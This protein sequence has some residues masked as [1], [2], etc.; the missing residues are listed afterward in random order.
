MNN[1]DE[2]SNGTELKAPYSP[3]DAFKK[4]MDK[5]SMR[6]GKAPISIE[7]LEQWGISRPVA[8]KVLP[9]LKFLRIVDR[10][11]LPT[12]YYSV[13]SLRDQTKREPKIHEILKNGYSKLLDTYADAFSFS[14]TQLS[15]AIGE[16]YGTSGNTRNAAV[17]FLRG[18]LL[19]AGFA[20]S[21]PSK[22]RVSRP[23]RQTNVQRTATGRT[24]KNP[25][26]THEGSLRAV[27]SSIQITVSVGANATEGD[28]VELL[29][30][31]K[32]A[33]AKIDDEG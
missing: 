6:S 19:L 7:T 28:L 23:Q 5:I 1:G 25:R 18:M 30:R 21:S 3:W 17:A 27:G 29:R 13:F 33:E 16:V 32:N 12:E 24:A 20:P 15:D 10:R 8:Y 11:G 26:A 2:T 22:T 9:A 4:V 31:I 14:D